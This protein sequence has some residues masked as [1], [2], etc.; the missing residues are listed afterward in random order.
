MPATFTEL[1]L[2]G[3]F[4][5][6]PEQY[7]DDR[8]FFSET[9]NKAGFISRDL[10][11]DWVQ[12]NYS[13]SRDKGVLRGLH[14]QR[15]PFAQDKLV[16]VCKGA[17]LDIAID[18]RHGSSH[19]GKWISVV[20]SAEKWN[21]LLIPIGFAHGFITLEPDTEVAYKV[22]APYSK[23]HDAG[24]RYNDPAIG[25]DWQLRGV[26]PLLSSKDANAPLLAD[27]D[28]GFVFAAVKQEPAT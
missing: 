3:V 12:D 4:E 5:I 7:P 8:G 25:V 27:Q 11:T 2:P 21:Q 28:P 9:F 18:I 20:L 14:Y 17:V 23:E 26:E 10:P 22:T 13:Y 1:A 15:A 24:I 19:Y 6:V 16:R